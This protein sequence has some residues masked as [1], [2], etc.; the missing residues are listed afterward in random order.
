MAKLINEL[1]LLSCMG[2]FISTKQKGEP[3]PRRSFVCRDRVR[4]FGRLSISAGSRTS[5][6]SSERPGARQACRQERGGKRAIS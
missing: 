2:G 6:E 5:S 4:G 1:L 3:G